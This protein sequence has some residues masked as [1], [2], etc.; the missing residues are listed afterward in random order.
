MYIQSSDKCQTSI[1]LS[2][3]VKIGSSRFIKLVEVSFIQFVH[4]LILFRTRSSSS[5][6]FI[7]FLSL[8]RSPILS[9]PFTV[10]VYFASLEV[11]LSSVCNAA[12][13]LLASMVPPL[14]RYIVCESQT[15]RSRVR[16]VRGVSSRLEIRTGP[17][18]PK[19]ADD[20]RGPD[21]RKFVCVYVCT[22][23]SVYL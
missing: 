13:D 12:I 16:R 3:S 9:F 2:P 23:L 18:P 21:A 19:S 11:H 14:P 4:L 5:P 6:S 20:A 1:L 8:P 7:R 15:A 22:C 10:K 17:K